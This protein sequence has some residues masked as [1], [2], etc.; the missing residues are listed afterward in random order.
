[1]GSNRGGYTFSSLGRV[2]VAPLPP[3]TANMLVTLPWTPQR[4]NFIKINSAES[5][6][7]KPFTVTINQIGYEGTLVK[8]QSFWED[9]MGAGLTIY[10]I[11]DTN[12]IVVDQ[13][14]DCPAIESIKLKI[15]GVDVP[16]TLKS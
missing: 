16:I 6:N 10:L 3:L 7:G 1:M 8:G 14:G 4:A 12:E 13:K 11:T 15:E 5:V 9:P 2:A